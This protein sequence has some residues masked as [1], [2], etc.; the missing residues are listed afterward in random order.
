MKISATIR[1]L[2]FRAGFNSHKQALLRLQPPCFHL[3]LLS[4]WSPESARLN[5]VIFQL[6]HLFDF[7]FIIE[8][9]FKIFVFQQ[10]LSNRRQLNASMT[11]ARHLASNI[12]HISKKV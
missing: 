5:W 11:Q 3:K 10:R 6:D 4:V 8:K 1:E 12:S 7:N 2:I 9:V